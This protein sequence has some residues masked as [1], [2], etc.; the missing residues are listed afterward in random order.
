MPCRMDALETVKLAHQM[1]MR[2]IVLKNSYFPT[3]P[4]AAIIEQLVPEVKSS[5]ASVSITKSGG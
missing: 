1:G 3:A 2:A 5:E 4:L